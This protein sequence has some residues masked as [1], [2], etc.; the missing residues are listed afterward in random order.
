MSKTTNGAGREREGGAAFLREVLAGLSRPRK[1]LPCKY[2]YDERGSQLFDRICELEEY[3]LTR[4]E[5]S[6]MQRHAREM[7]EA[8][9]AG[10]ALIELGSGSSVKTRLLLDHLVSPA[11]YLPLD[12]SEKHLL[13]TAALLRLR[14]PGIEIL[15]IV[16]DFAEK[17]S[18]P[19]AL[20]S[21]G[22]AAVYF[23][24]STI[25]NF[26]SEEAQAL[27][28][29]IGSLLRPGGS[30]LIGI[31][32]QKEPAVIEA[33]YNDAA[34]VTA[35]F[36]LN[37]LHRINRELRA[38]FDVAGFR[39][40]AAYDEREGR[41][42]LSVVS[43]REAAIHIQGREFCIARGEEILTEYSHKYTIEG[44]ARNAAR[45]GFVLRERWTDERDYFAILHLIRDR[46][47]EGGDV[48]G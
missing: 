37:L 33:A 23:P 21:P 29:R 18:L 19:S 47:T 32:L 43:Q 10:A 4:T 48:D 14:Y 1:A 17:F 24:G 2:F 20:R 45:V 9:G 34:G 28:R 7:A 16:A 22:R 27:L 31:D 13:R 12:I 8:L 35:E 11:A 3:Y 41:V 46:S 15:P 39:H 40:R 5:L 25:G 26:T 44:F 30:L 6:I 36:N 38:D 42:A